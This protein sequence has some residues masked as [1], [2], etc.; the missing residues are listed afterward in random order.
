MYLFLFALVC[1][2]PLASVSSV[3]LF[4]PLPVPVSAGL[5]ALDDCRWPFMLLD[6]A[7]G[8]IGAIGVSAR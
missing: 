6:T 1:V 4:F 5:S 7:I 2:F 8:E 3:F